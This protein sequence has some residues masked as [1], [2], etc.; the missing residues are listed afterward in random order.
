MSFSCTPDAVDFERR[1][2]YE[3][4]TKIYASMPQYHADLLPDEYMQCQF[5]L[6]CCEGDL[7][8]WTLVYNKIDTDSYTAFKITLD[9]Q[10]MDKVLPSLHMFDMRVKKRTLLEYN[11]MD[12]Q[13]KQARLNLLKDSMKVHAERIK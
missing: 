6:L 5:C 9:M 2:G 12:G 7:D 13:V 3:F 11:R 4:K 10:F 8:A 1:M